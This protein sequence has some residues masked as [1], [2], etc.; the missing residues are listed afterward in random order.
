[1]QEEV[2]LP[3][4]TSDNNIGDMSRGGKVYH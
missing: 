2:G 3:Y 4:L 1:M